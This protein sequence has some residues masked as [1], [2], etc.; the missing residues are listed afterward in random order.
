MG[1]MNDTANLAQGVVPFPNTGDELD[2]AGHAACGLV[3]KAALLAE[4]NTKHALNAAHKLSMQLR[5]AEDRIATLEA[6]NRRQRERA[7]RAEKWLHRI[8]MEIEDNFFGSGNGF[9]ASAPS[10]PSDYAPKKHGTY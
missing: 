8:A 6:D 7:D 10:A 9:T 4:E 1:M 2:R 5:A 3:H